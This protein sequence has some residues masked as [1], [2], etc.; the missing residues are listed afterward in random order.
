[1]FQY[2]RNVD[3]R[4][5]LKFLKLLTLLPMEEIKKYEN[6]EGKDLN[7]VKELLAYEVVK[8][9]HGEEE[10]KKA[11]E[12]ARSVFGKGQS[13][14]NMPTTE[15]DKNE[16]LEMTIIDVL[17]KTNLIKTNSEGRR[18]ITQGGITLGE[19]KVKD[20]NLKMTEDV[21]SD[22]EVIIKKGKKVF[23]KVSVK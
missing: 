1:M 9:V 20:P 21:L 14:V 19:E 15:I 18:L 7:I 13:S 10:A 12:A 2:L 11:L 16:F 5:A 22:N 8:D 23:H 6:Y 4:D 3:D 17:N